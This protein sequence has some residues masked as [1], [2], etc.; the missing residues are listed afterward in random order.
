[1]KFFL[2]I[3]VIIFIVCSF[4]AAPF[5]YAEPVAGY[6]CNA[7]TKECFLDLIKDDTGDLS[8]PGC[9]AYDAAQEASLAKKGFVIISGGE[10]HRRMEQDQKYSFCDEGKNPQKEK[11][12]DA[13]EMSSLPQQIDGFNLVGYS[14]GGQKAWDI[15]G[16]KANIQ[17]DQV[18]VT[19]VNANSYGDEDMN[20]KAKKGTL[21]KATGNVFLEKD[22]VVTSEGGAQMKTDTL[23][24]QRQ[25]DLVQTSDKVVIQDEEM[26]VSGVG[27]E[28]HPSTRAAKLHGDVTANISAESSGGKKDNR[29]EITSDG[30]MDLDQA[31][32]KA[33]FRDNVMAIE[34]STGR[35]L[36][37]DQM[38][39]IFDEKSKK[40]KE[41]VCTG[42]VELHQDGNVTHSEVLVYKADEQRMTLTGRP[43]LLIDPGTVDTKEFFKY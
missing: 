9:V 37:A 40:I 1:M 3:V 7:A 16:D 21:D 32:Q 15:K 33:V 24:W 17:G 42:N 30:P 22:V 14:D 26:M 11:T 35:K 2:G 28:A 25:K 19:N 39:V 10:L 12:G 6:V 5:V 13:K 29:I 36:K 20:I 34:L 8:F 31:K 4:T 41:I 23:E 38:D 18:D 43:K 27:M